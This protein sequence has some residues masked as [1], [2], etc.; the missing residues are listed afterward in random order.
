MQKANETKPMMQ[1]LRR[2]F[3][4]T[5]GYTGFLLWIRDG[6][7]DVT[8]ACG[9]N[10]TPAWL[11][12]DIERGREYMNER[13]AEM[14]KYIKENPGKVRVDEDG[15]KWIPN[16]TEGGV[17]RGAFTPGMVLREGLATAEEIF[18]WRREQP[19]LKVGM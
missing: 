17:S 15:R 7:P 9:C 2:I 6:H 1:S 14:V 8:L 18:N 11:F 19:F 3:C 13:R 12:A 16:P 10:N 5:C 4:R